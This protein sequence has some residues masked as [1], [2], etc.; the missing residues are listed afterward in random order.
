[1]MALTD[2]DLSC[3]HMPSASVLLEA[4]VINR[5][6][7]MFS[8]RQAL[9]NSVDPDETPQNAAS[10]QGL[11]CLPLNQQFLDTTSGSKL[12]LFKF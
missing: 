8:E 7:R 5:I 6:F 1:M 2:L 3:P 9:A 12:Y 10:H 4:A 11:H